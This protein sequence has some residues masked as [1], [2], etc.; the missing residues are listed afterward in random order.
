M[1]FNRENYAKIKQEYAG[2]YLRA[3][4]EAQLRRAEVH[5]CIP[6][7]RDIDKELSLTGL[8]IFK[9][10]MMNDK[11]VLDAINQK[12]RDL[13]E[14]RARFLE[15]RGFA[16]NYT[17]IKYECS[18]CGDTGVV[19]NRMCRC[20]K[21]KLI[22]AGFESSGMRDLIR[23]QSFDNFDLGYYRQNEAT[24]VRMSAIYT[25]LKKYA[26]GFDP[27]MSGSIA[28]F[29]GTGLGKT[30]L[31]SAVAG[32]VIENGNDV[33]YTSAMNM[34]SD[35]EQ[36]RFGASAGFDTTGD[37][38][39]YFTCDLLII[40]DIGTEVANQF[41]VSC[42]YNVINTRLNRRKPTVLSTN[43]TQDEFRKRYWDRI[44]SRV[45]GEFLVLPFLGD[46][47]RRQKIDKK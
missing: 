30:H 40:D 13:L 47:I 36:K 12:N 3:Q 11:A 17:E 33:Y 37:V 41:T 23:R 10:T 44:S 4:E 27:E 16:P 2:K 7:I 24:Y 14:R 42:L 46:D 28:M 22:E 45:F 21:K 38:S 26:D 15:E 8:E 35:F 31:S 34:F 39:Q 6:D 1:G 20:M 19:G 29:G 32:V 25:T 9:A 5:A 18:E 43:L